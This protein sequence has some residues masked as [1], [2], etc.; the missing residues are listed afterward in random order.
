MSNSEVGDAFG[1]AI[2]LSANSSV[3]VTDAIGEASVATGINDDGS[4]L[5]IGVASEQSTDIGIDAN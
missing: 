3:L 2:A 5:A 1:V 4:V